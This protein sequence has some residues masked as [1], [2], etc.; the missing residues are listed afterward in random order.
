MTP[1]AQLVKSRALLALGQA[2]DAL[3]AVERGLESAR[4]QGL[5]YEQALLLRMRADLRTNQGGA[6]VAT[7]STD[8]AEA[9]R[10]LA[11][12]GATG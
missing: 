6:G 9:T 5:P 2:T 1:R 4:V 10:L 11:A 7:A 3:Q 12:L 8:A